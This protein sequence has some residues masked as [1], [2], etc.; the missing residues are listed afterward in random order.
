MYPYGPYVKS[1]L[2][3]SKSKD[4]SG[5]RTRFGSAEVSLSTGKIVLFVPEAVLIN[6][7][8][9]FLCTDLPQQHCKSRIAVQYKCNTKAKLPAK[10]GNWNHKTQAS[11]SSRLISFTATISRVRKGKDLQGF[12]EATL[13]SSVKGCV[14]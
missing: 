1:T 10:V 5:V 4:F 12:W 7:R 9:F 8:R 2:F 13:R 11:S 14:R 6:S 3:V